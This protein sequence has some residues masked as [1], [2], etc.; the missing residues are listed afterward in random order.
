[1]YLIVAVENTRAVHLYRDCGFIEEGHLV[2]EFFING[3]YRDVKRM[4]VLQ[5]AYLKRLGS[6]D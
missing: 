6:R 5:D 4:Y 1:M 3:R 2:Q